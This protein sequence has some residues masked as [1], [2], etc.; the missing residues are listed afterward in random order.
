MQ[1]TLKI[2]GFSLVTGET[3]FDRSLKSRILSWKGI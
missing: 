3:R 2:L 1:R